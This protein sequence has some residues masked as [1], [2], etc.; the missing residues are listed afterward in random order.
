M[1]RCRRRA[2][3]PRRPEV[4]LGTQEQSPALTLG[5]PSTLDHQDS[6]ERQQI[7]LKGGLTI[8]AGIITGNILGFVRVALTASLLGTHSR[9][10]SLA[11]AI[12]P[13]DTLNAV[14]INSMVFAFVPMLTERKGA[15]RLALFLRL[16]RLFARGFTVVALTTAIF[17]GWLITVLAPGLDPH[18][19][20]TA[21]NILR[22]VSLSTLAA[23]MAAI[24]AA[25]LYTDRRFAP[26]AFYQASLNVFTIVGALSLWKVF[27]VYGFA[28]GYSIGAWV[29]FGIV[30]YS[31]RRG[32]KMD[33]LPPCDLDWRKIITRP[34][35]ILMYAA[36]LALN[37]TFTRG[38]ATNAGPGMAA[39]LDYC[40]RGITVPLAFLVSPI[41][42]SL[43]PEIARLRAQL[44]L[45]EA[46]H[47]IDKTIALAALAA[48]AGCVIAVAL[49]QPAIHI[50]FER[51]EFT[52]QS[53]ILVSAVFLG[54]GPSM[55]GWSLLELTSRSLFALD[56]PLLPTIAAAIPV[57][58]NVIVT[59]STRR[60]EPQFIGLGASIGLLA[61]F[62]FV[63]IAATI[64]R[65]TS[66]PAA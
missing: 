38:Y 21:A 55:I 35:T 51:G 11:V 58:V 49:R 9:A 8:G 60:P 20:D 63:F 19:H 50:L 12:G 23:G 14:L 26:S 3:R 18:Y 7:L 22:I 25:L 30:W 46:W 44:R 37:I 16:H 64:S 56:R 65:K 24:H 40:M 53:T 6:K 15:D 34:G 41:S 57:V 2:R 48:V 45:R 36:A 10:D 47:L 27:G 17:A 32:L 31:A 42:N 29:Q 1:P 66:T 52:A 59:L 4:R 54:L 33:N 13:I 62:L 5:K 43:L 39:A 61:G 28:V